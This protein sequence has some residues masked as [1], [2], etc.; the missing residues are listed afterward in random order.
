MR[1]FT[2]VLIFLNLFLFA[3]EPKP[4]SSIGIGVFMSESEYEGDGD[5]EMLVLPL[6]TYQGEK[7]YARGIELGYRYIDTKPFKFNFT[8][9]PKLNSYKSSDSE[10]LAGMDNRER[11]LE[12]GVSASLKV[13]PLVTFSA[14]AKFDTLSK[15]NGYDIG[16]GIG[17]FIPLSKSFFIAPSYRKIYLSSNNADYYY[18]VK[19]SEATATRSVYE[20]GST[21]ITRYGVNFI[22]NINKD[23][24]TSLMVNKT[25]FSDEIRNSPIVKDK[26]IVSGI[27]ALS[28][29]F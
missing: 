21:D 18:G 6:L 28:Y 29:K 1:I 16:L 11:T 23:I 22:Y 20:V 9:N 3:D 5:K 4:R 25:K 24:S 10:Y 8:L 15:H 13:I 12:A 26:D 2:L 17:V 19:Q 14:R 27:L 7:F